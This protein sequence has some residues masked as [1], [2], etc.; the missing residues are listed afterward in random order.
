MNI[1]LDLIKSHA[2]WKKHRDIN[3]S[4]AKSVLKSV[5][6]HFP[7]YHNVLEVEI[8]I[9]L[10]SDAH[11]QSLNLEFMS[12]NK[13]TNVLSFPEMEIKS[14]SALAFLPPKDYIYLGDIAFGYE[15]VYA[16]SAA[17]QKTFIAHF[18]H[19]LTHG[20]LHLVGMDHEEAQEAV[21]M[22]SIEIA[23]IRDFDIPSPY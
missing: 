19:L 5:L 20:I 22:Q 13:P 17:E 18:I 15:V 16:E 4:L 10:T 9:L 14:S 11:M 3:K 21:E 2:P 7:N 12:K 6:R 8:A 1:T 23:V